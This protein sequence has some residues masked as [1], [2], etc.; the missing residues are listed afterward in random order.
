MKI[1]LG[2]VDRM[3]IEMMVPFGSFKA[4]QYFMGKN[5]RICS[6]ELTSL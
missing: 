4:N 5:E 1:R 3:K 6:A 2:I